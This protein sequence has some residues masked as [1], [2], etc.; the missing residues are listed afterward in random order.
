V[1]EDIKVKTAETN[2][3]ESEDGE[4][5]TCSQA[6]HAVEKEINT[7]TAPSKMSPCTNKYTVKEEI[8]EEEPATLKNE[9]ENNENV[10]AKKCYYK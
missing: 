6:N 4:S 5:V 1:E 9:D 2:K 8:P 10:P 3:T 7:L